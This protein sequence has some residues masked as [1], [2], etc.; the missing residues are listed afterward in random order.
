LIGYC[1][2]EMLG[3]GLS[4]IILGGF[5]LRIFCELLKES[6][7]NDEELDSHELFL[8]QISFVL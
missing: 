7:F 1:E 6:N 3:P 4:S 5:V 8:S 2:V